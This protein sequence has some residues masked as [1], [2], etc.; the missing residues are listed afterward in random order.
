VNLVLGG[1][2]RTGTGTRRLNGVEWTCAIE[3]PIWCT[4]SIL[5]SR[6]LFFGCSQGSAVARPLL[7]GVGW[8]VREAEGAVEAP[9]PVDLALDGGP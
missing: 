2:R 6:R 9:V 5:G 7:V 8:L 4:P 3:I 1:K